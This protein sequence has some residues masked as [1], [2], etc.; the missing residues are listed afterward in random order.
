MFIRAAS[1]RGSRAGFAVAAPKSI[2]AAFMF[3][4][5]AV[6]PS[7]TLS[8][9]FALNS[10]APVTRAFVLSAYCYVR[11]VLF[12]DCSKFMSRV[13]LWRG[14][15]RGKS[16][17]GAK[18]SSKCPV[19]KPDQ[20]RIVI[21]DARAVHARRDDPFLQ[22]VLGR[23]VQ[24]RGRIAADQ[25]RPDLAPAENYRHP[26]MKAAH[27]IVSGPDNDRRRVDHLLCLWDWYAF[28]EPS[29][30]EQPAVRR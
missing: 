20:C 4:R 3:E 24:Q 14:R 21:A 29:E 28:P 10:I 19:L 17:P 27:P 6:S 11:R 5:A 8:K 23:R 2:L 18:R 1:P 22:R 16:A 30:G 13:S 26:I 15:G 7:P 12:G 9:S 25:P